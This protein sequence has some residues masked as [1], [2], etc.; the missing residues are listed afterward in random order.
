MEFEEKEIPPSGPAVVIIT[1][2]RLPR[3]ALSVHNTD[4]KRRWMAAPSIVCQ[5]NLL[6][7]YPGAFDSRSVAVE[8]RHK[9]LAPRAFIQYNDFSSSYK[10]V[11]W[12]WIDFHGTSNLV[13]RISSHS[14]RLAELLRVLVPHGS[15]TLFSAVVV[16]CPTQSRRD[17]SDGFPKAVI[18]QD[19]LIAAAEIAE[20]G[21][22]VLSCHHQKWESDDT[23]AV[24]FCEQLVD[25]VGMTLGL[26]AIHRLKI[27]CH[28]RLS[29]KARWLLRNA[30]RAVTIEYE[31]DDASLVG[32][33]CPSIRG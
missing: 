22:I 12:R 11:L 15:P 32:W 6:L 17:Q 5:E 16:T 30:R 27:H 3:L 13:V 25:M 20:F 14:T 28:L 4:T 1:V 23:A 8:I 26:V 24:I 19:A 9:T 21:Y 2:D 18:Q 29:D 31:C 10:D 33:S 7:G